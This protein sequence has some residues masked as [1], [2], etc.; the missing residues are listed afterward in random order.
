MKKFL[1]LLLCLSAMVLALAACSGKN[2][3][4]EDKGVV[5]PVYLSTEVANF[6][7]AYSNLDDATTRVLGLI[8]E[9]LF[10]YDGNGKVVKS[11]AKSVKVLDRPSEDYYAIEIKLK[12]TCWSDGTQVQAA[13]YIYAWK[14]ILEPEFRGE[15]AS[16][17]FDIKNA[18]DVNRGDASIDDLGLTDVETDVIRIEFEGPTDYDKFYEYLASPMLVPLREIAVDKVAKDWSS[19]SSI[20]VCNGPFCLRSYIPGERMILE[21]NIYYYRDIE[22]D[23]LKKYVTPYR[24][25][26]NFTKDAAG[27]LSEYENGALVYDSEIPLA[28]RKDYKD[29]AKVTD[30]M[31]VL[32]YVFNTTKA[33]FDNAD[34][35]KALSL[36]ID[37]NQIVDILTFAKPAE[38]L[39]GDGVFENGYA[40]KNASF[41]SH[42]EKL[43]SAEADV[44]AAKNLLSKAG[45]SGGDIT[46]TLRNNEADVAVAEYVKSVWESLGFTVTLNP[47]GYTKYTDEREYDLVTDA[48][49][50]AYENRNF[51][52]IS[53][54]WQMLT[55]DAFP[56]LAQF[57]K[58]FASGKMDMNVDDEGEYELATHVSGYYSEAYDAKLEEIFGIKDDGAARA[59]LLHEAE[60]MLLD[61]MPIMPLVQLQQATVTS[62]DVKIPGTS[63]FGYDYFAK[64]SLKNASKYPENEGY[65]S[66]AA[67]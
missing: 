55:T 31:S 43:I 63:Y 21:R 6:D 50:E 10:K 13:D 9:G 12:Y 34:V 45:V 35:R 30:T 56:N 29:S 46:I 22:D 60:A 4:E 44:T 17:L 51:D 57:S 33:P 14:R 15:A 59:A 58:A 26:V 39:I 49:L 28:N 16:M 67:E 23:S 52:V 19:S 24:L 18:R 11:Q 62:S 3:E 32:S 54:D 41:R 36:A 47:L 40:K 2:G 38:G 25:M 61:D 37:R 7:P 27:N 64:A 8:Y 1:V 53:V 48:Y 65:G 42:G 66:E 5:I 20:V